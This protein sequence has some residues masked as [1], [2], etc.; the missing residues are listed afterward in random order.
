MASFNF[1]DQEI[2]NFCQHYDEHSILSQESSGRKVIEMTAGVVVKFGI[3]VTVQEAN[4]QQL[5][6]QKINSKALRIP[7]VYRF[8]SR[9]NSELWSIGYVAME[10]IE[11]VNLEQGNWDASDLCQRVAASLNALH[12]VSSDYPGPVS[13]GEAQGHLWSED[14]SGTAFLDTKHL[15]MYFLL[16]ETS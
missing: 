4:A 8:F 10:K 2:L 15:E 1:S 14:G 12:S 16:L 6:F 13:G 11:G 3:G 9:Q 5:A 7:R